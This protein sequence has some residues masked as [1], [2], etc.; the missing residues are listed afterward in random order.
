M[1]ML[2]AVM[3]GILG[4]FSR[5]LPGDDYGR[6]YWALTLGPWENVL[7]RRSLWGGSYSRYFIHGFIAPYDTFA[8]SVLPIVNIILLILGLSWLGMQ[9]L[10]CLHVKRNKLA[11]SVSFAS[12]AAAASIHGQYV[13]EAFYWFSGS[14]PY[15]LPVI[16]FM[17]FLAA[18]SFVAQKLQSGKMLTAFAIAGAGICFVLAGFSEM[19]LAFQF[20]ASLLLLLALG[21]AVEHTLRWKV[22]ALLGAGIFGALCS[23]VV[24]VTAEGLHVR[25]AYLEE[26]PYSNPIRDLPELAVQSLFDVY[27]LVTHHETMA[28]FILL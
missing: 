10:N 20:S 15:F 25:A 9:V 23:L 7:N 13:P 28:G 17:V 2:P 4:Q 16:L 12:I 14:G 24:Y 19:H 3:Y 5:M 8:V 21:I 27:G 1:A 26:F 18:A 22:I 11:L 6:M